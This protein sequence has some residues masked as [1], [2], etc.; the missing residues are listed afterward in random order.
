M[1]TQ[2]IPGVIVP[3][4]RR[5]VEDAA[6]YWT[7]HDT[8][9]LSPQV[10]LS[11]LA[12]MSQLLRAHLD[13]LDVA[14]LHAWPHCHAALVRWQKSAEA[15]VCAWVALRRSDRAEVDQLLKAVRARP[16]VLL[17]GVISAIAWLPLASARERIAQWTAPDG[18][19]VMQ[20]AAL[21]AAA[22]VGTEAGSALAQP[23]ATFLEADDEHV[24][25]A[26]CRVA[27]HGASASANL[28][29][30]L[31]DPA[32]A[33][34]AEAA[35]ALSVSGSGD[36]LSTAVL[37]ECAA[38]QTAVAQAATGWHATQARRRLVRWVR[39]LAM[40]P[41]SRPPAFA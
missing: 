8:S 35:I 34:R 15:F 18:D 39:H 27:G 24:R 1:T 2:S 33:V 11:A 23:L 26:A 30:L 32:L 25:A 38:S 36:T 4:V 12:R 29:R 41:A 16:H 19:S 10:R 21:R 5:H 13:G 14:G 20:V 22:L 9:A 6:F 28:G 37:W 31:D 40:L 17:R 3:L 7:Q